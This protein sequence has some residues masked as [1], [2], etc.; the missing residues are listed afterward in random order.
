MKKTRKPADTENRRVALAGATAVLVL[1][2]EGQKRC[3]TIKEIAKTVWPTGVLTKAMQK[4]I[5]KC[6]G[7]III[8]L[9]PDSFYH[10][11][12][13]S[14]KVNKRMEETG[15][16]IMPV[17]AEFFK[18]SEKKDRWL[19]TEDE[20]K[21]CIPGKGPRATA[22]LCLADYSDP[23]YLKYIEHQLAGF[24]GKGRHLIGR[25]MHAVENE[26]LDNEELKEIGMDVAGIKKITK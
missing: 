4:D 17:T 11:D 14:G 19:F 6:I 15:E 5:K 22:G 25:T 20:V 3:C 21:T 18:L 9:Q 2:T 23:V 1:L 16:I 8:H 12:S 13:K 26:A 24:K 10:P 7:E